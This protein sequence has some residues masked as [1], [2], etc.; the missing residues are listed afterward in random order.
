[1][2]ATSPLLLRHSQYYDTYR[3]WST[4]ML[5]IIKN[6]DA[7]HI[8]N[9]SPPGKHGDVTTSSS[10]KCISVSLSTIVIIITT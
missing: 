1:M 3:S 2:H 10:R 6:D 5:F 8:S 4:Q 9:A 7:D